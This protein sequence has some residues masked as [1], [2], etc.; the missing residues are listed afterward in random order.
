MNFEI[1]PINTYS[2]AKLDPKG[3]KPMI[4]PMTGK[5]LLMN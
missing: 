3:I 2:N 1:Y 4:K 5:L